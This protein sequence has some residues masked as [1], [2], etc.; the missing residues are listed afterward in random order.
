MGN[1]EIAI[2]REQFP[3][4]LAFAVT[5]N[6]QQGS[7][8]DHGLVDLSTPLN[9]NLP[10]PY[11]TVALSRFRHLNDMTIVDNFYIGILQTQHDIN[12]LNEEIRYKKIA[13]STLDK[14]YST[15][16]EYLSN[17]DK[18]SLSDYVKSK[19]SYFHIDT[20]HTKCQKENK[21][22]SKKEV[23][24]LNTNCTKLDNYF[25]KLMN[26]NENAC[27]ANVCLQLLLSCGEYF[28]TA[29]TPIQNNGEL[30]LLLQ[31]CITAFKS[32]ESKPFSTRS[33]REK[34]EIGKRILLWNDDSMDEML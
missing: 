31:N 33:I 3:L 7:T 25:L 13:N 2:K 1:L 23:N 30:S 32:K 8:V 24:Y 20:E 17:K 14:Y 10:K 21:K 22:Q 6:N 11:S 27:Y 16:K 29:I 18:I 9:G 26:N 19:N 15:Q 12:L 5:C 28:F 4:M 34:V